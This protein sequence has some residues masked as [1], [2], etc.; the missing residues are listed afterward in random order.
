MTTLPMAAAPGWKPSTPLPLI[1]PLKVVV[2]VLATVIV[3]TPAIWILPA[4]LIGLVPPTV[5]GALMMSIELLI[6][7]ALP[8]PSL[9]VA[10]WI[11]AACVEPLMSVIVPVPNELLLPTLTVPTVVA[12]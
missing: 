8:V 4:K 3:D 5:H 2:A 12:V 6:V 7:S 9:A 10:A 1:V 11:T